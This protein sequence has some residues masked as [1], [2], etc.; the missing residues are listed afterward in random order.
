MN[1]NYSANN[2]K[3]AYKQIGKFN[4]NYNGL[5]DSIKPYINQRTCTRSYRICIFDNTYQR[6]HIGAQA[7]QLNF[8]F[9]CDVVGTICHALVLTRGIIS[10]DTDDS[11][12]VD[13]VS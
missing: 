7:K 9:A 4:G 13:I 10:V 3:V 11:K 2:S 12:M 6:F 1:I 8:K 5:L